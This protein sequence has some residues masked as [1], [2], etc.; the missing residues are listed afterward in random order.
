M[1]VRGNDGENGLRG[2]PSEFSISDR[3]RDIILGKCSTTWGNLTYHSLHCVVAGLSII[4]IVLVVL[5]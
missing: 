3:Q 2:R 1:V 5:P 4:L